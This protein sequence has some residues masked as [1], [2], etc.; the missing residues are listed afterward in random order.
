M[1]LFKSIFSTILSFITLIEI[2]IGS[3][4]TG[5]NFKIVVPPA[6]YESGDNMYT[7]IWTTNK[8]GSGSVS[9]TYEGKEYVANDQIGGN[10]RCLDTIHSVRVPK[11]HLDN[12]TYTVSSQYVPY[13][14]GYQAIKGKTVTS[15]PI[16]FRGYNNQESVKALV[17]SDIHENMTPVRK[18]ISAFDETPDLIILNGDIVSTIE[19]KEKISWIFECASEVSG[20]EIPVVYARGN[21]EPRGEYASEMMS[22]FK[23]STGNLYFTFNYGPVWSIVLDCGE[24]KPDNHGEYSGLVDF[25]AYIAEETKW[26]EKLDPDTS[27]E[28]IYRL[29]I[30][31]NPEFEDEYGNDWTSA[32]EKQNLDLLIAG[33]WHCLNLNFKEGTTSFERWITG[34]KSNNG[35][36]ASMITF[37]NGKIK[38]LS[39][40]DEGNISGKKEIIL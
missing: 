9:Y 12:N 3:P 31:H 13:K 14:G 20:G 7:V 8:R 1:T 5:S 32:L 29:G 11:E 28:T 6:V 4:I 27:E 36:I 22:Y 34:G 15:E 2:A 33:H 17:L 25:T 35:F 39:K 38:I 26:L 21:H 24:D 30:S 18:A 19:T 37:G 23:T 16:H 10:I 40:D